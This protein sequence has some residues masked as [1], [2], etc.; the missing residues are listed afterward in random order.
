M[1]RDPACVCWVWDD[2]MI[3]HVPKSKLLADCS[4]DVHLPW[5]GSNQCN[6]SKVR[7]APSRPRSWAHCSRAHCSLHR[8]VPTGMRGPTSVLSY[9]LP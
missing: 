8:C 6:C 5:V 9:G 7:Q 1:P 4:A 3:S 2:R